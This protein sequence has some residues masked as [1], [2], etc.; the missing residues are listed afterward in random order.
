MALGPVRWI[1][2]DGKRVQYRDW[3]TDP[4]DVMTLLDWTAEKLGINYR[5]IE[6]DFAHFSFDP[7][8]LPALLFAGH[9][10]FELTD[11]VRPKLARYVADGGTILGDAC[12]GWK[13][14]AESFRREMEAIFPDRPLHKMLP[15][16]PIFPPITSW[17]SL[18]YKKA[19]GSTYTASRAWKRST[20]AA[21][22][23]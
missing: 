12:C 20:S 22:A 19:D 2:K 7:R 8:E 16:E 11:E 14:F 13:D 1:T 4:A 6:A 9:N 23:A 17:G 10:K 15:E 5:A 18:T 3:M 21:A